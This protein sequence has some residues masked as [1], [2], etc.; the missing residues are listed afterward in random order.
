MFPHSVTASR[1]RWG[2][3]A[4]TRFN[5]HG[6]RRATAAKQPLPRR[7]HQPHNLLRSPLK[8]LELS[9]GEALAGFGDEGGVLREVSEGGIERDTLLPQRVA[10][11]VEP[12]DL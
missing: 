7:F 4:L 12:L 5:W 11:A 3:L 6:W 8:S 1:L 10:A 2:A 9:L